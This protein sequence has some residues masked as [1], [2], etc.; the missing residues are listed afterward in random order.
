[1]DLRHVR[2]A[3]TIARAGSLRRAAAILR[4]AQPTLSE[5][6]RAL[7]KEVGVELFSRS[8]SGVRLTE[9]G[10]VFLAQ[11]TV[12]VEAFER[13]V[14]A[15]HG[16]ERAARLGVADGLSDVAAR[17][18]SP[19]PHARLRVTPMGTAEQIISLVDGT[20]QAGLG[21][22]PGSL[23]RGVA[24]MLVH[25][26]P[27]RALLPRDHRLASRERVPL[28]ELAAEP[29]VMP[30][31]EAVAG[32]RRF[33]EAFVRHRLYPRLGPSAAT[34]ELAVTLVGEGAGYTLCVREGAAVPERLRF[35]PVAEEMPPIEVVLLWNRQAGVPELVSAARHLARTG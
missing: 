18:L 6:L 11:A 21:Y 22:A 31:S 4:I 16:K 32:A 15:A 27:V 26:S 14:T 7:E 17:L 10:E 20:I 8:S 33:L 25:R 34:H 2:Y 9:A 30:E 1:M 35:V 5:Q 19:L 24:R 29:L 23:P 12:A 28:A 3:I 13:A